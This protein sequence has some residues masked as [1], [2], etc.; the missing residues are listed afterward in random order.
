MSVYE[1]VKAEFDFPFSPHVYQAE[2]LEELEPMPAS[3]LRFRVGYGKTVVSTI[4]A[5]NTA[6]SGGV[7]QILVLCPPILLDQWAEWLSEVGG[8]PSVDI[9]RG[10]PKQRKKMDIESASIILMSY[11]IFRGDRDFTRIEKM[12]KSSKFCIIADELSLK[13]L[14]SSTYK[15]LKKVMYRKMRLT[16]EDEPFHRLI[17]LNA[18]PISDPSQVYNW[19]AMMTP[20]VYRSYQQFK[21][22][23]AGPED[24]WG[25]VLTWHEEELM[26][27]NMAAFTVDTDTEL[28]LPKLV[29]I[30][31]PYALTP[32]HKALYEEVLN[33]CLDNLPPD[34]IELAANS[35]FSTLQRLVLTPAEYGLDIKPPILDY[36]EGVLDQCD[37]DDGI[38]IYT[39]HV[40]VSKLLAEKIPNS[41]AIYGGVSQKY[42]Q[43]AFA[44]LKAGE[45]RRLIGN[46]DSLDKGMNLQMLNRTICAEIPFKDDKL[47]QMIGRTH[48][49]G[50]SKNCFV[51]YPL[52]I[53]TIQQKI[54]QKCLVNG[55]GIGRIMRDKN[56][57]REFLS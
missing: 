35:M 3:L 23:H 21:N 20:G 43:E 12:L 10:T 52:A 13:S 4:F 50:Q 45:I 55:E 22:I 47:T 32:A 54:F 42:R 18:T 40:S 46:M 51:H 9:Y 41:V 19:C 53:G 33:E 25:K 11:N 34:K 48:R 39:R 15:K 7:E 37:E 17:A 44:A 49:Q 38:L 28:V 14:T 1:R 16:I 2:A 56:S 8:I 26:A 5:L 29:E 6:I 27:D 36:L 30:K 57:I 24:H 31:T